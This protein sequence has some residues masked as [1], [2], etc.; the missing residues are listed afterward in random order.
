MNIRKIKRKN[1]QEKIE[2]LRFEFEK[3]PAIVRHK[4]LPIFVSGSYARE[5]ASEYSDIDLFFIY[6]GDLSKTSDP[7]IASIRLFSK[8]VEIADRLK[9]QKIFK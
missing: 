4:H 1:S 9:F 8:I 5:E 3:E 6:N 2:N 7:N